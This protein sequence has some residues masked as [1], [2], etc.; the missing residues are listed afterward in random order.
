MSFLVSRNPAWTGDDYLATAMSGW[1]DYSGCQV[2]AGSATKGTLCS[3]RI[4][5]LAPDETTAREIARSVSQT[6]ARSAQFV[7]ALKVMPSR[8]TALER[9]S[10]RTD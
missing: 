2:L 5:Y 1:E 9:G 10:R 3:V 8:A 6:C 7:D 4:R